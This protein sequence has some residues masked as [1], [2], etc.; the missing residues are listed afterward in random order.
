MRPHAEDLPRSRRLQAAELQGHR[1]TQSG[2]WA[3]RRLPGIGFVRLLQRRLAL[4]VQRA[5]PEPAITL[6]IR[7]LLLAAR[8]AAQTRRGLVVLQIAAC[9]L[10]GASYGDEQHSLPCNNRALQGA[11]S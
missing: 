4:L 11:G 10:D 9:L 2:P 7:V 5:A 1:A 3:V 6:V 8:R